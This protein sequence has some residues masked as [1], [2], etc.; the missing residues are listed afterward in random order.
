MHTRWQKGQSGNARGRK[1]GTPNAD[2]LI[3]EFMEAQ[4]PVRT[5]QGEK[6]MSRQM[7]GI[8]RAWDLAA[9]GNLNA[10]RQLQT[11]YAEA[12]ARRAGRE[13]SDQVASAE[14]RAM[15]DEFMR[16]LNLNGPEDDAAQGPA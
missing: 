10:L 6:R 13:I 14:E 1:K 11:S 2:T 3:I 12:K 15:L 16:A 4:I 8:H 9:K 7:A 5:A